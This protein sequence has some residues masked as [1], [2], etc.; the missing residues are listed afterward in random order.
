MCVISLNHFQ[1]T[2][3]Q[4]H[5]ESI[6]FTDNNAILLLN[7]FHLEDRLRSGFASFIAK[8]SGG[9]MTSKFVDKIDPYHKAALKKQRKSEGSSRY[10]NKDV[11]EL[12]PLPLVK[13]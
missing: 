9:N 11:V 7:E 5:R 10:R 6:C 3:V 8:R 2:L 1:C 13:G 4:E 12:Q